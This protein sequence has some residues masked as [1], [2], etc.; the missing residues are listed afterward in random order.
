MKRLTNI[1]KPVVVFIGIL[2]LLLASASACSGKPVPAMT[3]YYQIGQPAETSREVLTAVSSEM[4]SQYKKSFP[5]R[6]INAFEVAP[7]GTVFVILK[8]SVT[9]VG[10]DSL[11]ISYKDFYMKDSLGRVWP[12]TGYNGEE[13]SYPSRKLASGQSDYG[14]IAFNPLET[15]TGLQLCCVLQGS[16]PVLAVWQLPY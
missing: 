8:V 13:K 5:A 4:V 12:C 15:A 7:P 3:V 11:G 10:Q 16:P 6:L 2:A 1:T 14:Y 9:N